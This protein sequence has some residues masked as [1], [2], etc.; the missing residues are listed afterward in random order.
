MK[1]KNQLFTLFLLLSTQ[2]HAGGIGVGNGLTG[3][4]GDAV[5]CFDDQKNIKSAEFLDLFEARA[6]FGKTVSL[7]DKSLSVDQKIAL[8]VTRMQQAHFSNLA[9]DLLIHANTFL[10]RSVFVNTD[11]SDIHD[12]GDLL[13]PSGCAE[14]QAIIRARTPDLNGKTFTIDRRLWDL[15]DN[16]SKTAAIMHEFFYARAIDLYKQDNSENARRL[17]AELLSVGPSEPGSLIDWVYL[18]QSLQLGFSE[19]WGCLN[20]NTPNCT[21]PVTLNLSNQGTSDEVDLL[22]FNTSQA[23]D[24][25]TSD[26]G[27]IPFAPGKVSLYRFQG[28]T[29]AA[30]T[31]RD[32]HTFNTPVGIFDFNGTFSILTY[33]E[34]PATDPDFYKIYSMNTGAIRFSKIGTPYISINSDSK[35]TWTVGMLVT[36]PKNPDFYFQVDKPDAPT[37]TLKLTTTSTQ[38]ANTTSAKA[39]DYSFT[40]TGGTITSPYGIQTFKGTVSGSLNGGNLSSTPAPYNGSEPE[41]IGVFPQIQ[42]GRT[43]LKNLPFTSLSSDYG[44]SLNFASTDAVTFSPRPGLTLNGTLER[45]NSD[46][47]PTLYGNFVITSLQSFSDNYLGLAVSRVSAQQDDQSVPTLS[48]GFERAPPFVGNALKWIKSAQVENY[49]NGHDAWQDVPLRQIFSSLPATLTV[50]Q[51]GNLELANS[52]CSEP[53]PLITADVR[54][55]LSAKGFFHFGQGSFINGFALNNYNTYHHTEVTGCLSK[56]G[57]EISN[58]ANRY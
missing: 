22:I 14:K 27:M 29:H 51:N 44:I 55:K 48:I 35:C 24:I 7:G 47:T 16:D 21:D 9:A 33:W 15:M 58:I 40:V 3:N 37:C 8:V 13:F 53:F 10:A 54:L 41:V 26:Q 4:G 25:L 46:E 18:F 30:G 19:S 43:I 2:V 45:W 49:K 11:L 1:L 32:W 6:V 17:N 36:N 39:Q 31:L 42:I 38:I 57:L 28:K 50:F 52:D 20:T 5:I 23:I 34:V 56:N 12:A